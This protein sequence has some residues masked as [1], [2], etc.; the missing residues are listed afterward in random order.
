MKGCLTQRYKGSWSIVLDV[1]YQM[2]P[3][4]GVRK[5]KQ[6]CITV[7]GHPARCRKETRRTSSMMRTGSSSSN[8]VSARSGSGSMNGSRKPSKPAKASRSL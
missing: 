1:G 4:T 3:I 8:R 7:R 5:R 6:R 2:D